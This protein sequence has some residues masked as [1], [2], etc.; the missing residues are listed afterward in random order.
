MDG[1]SCGFLQTRYDNLKRMNIQCHAETPDR[2]IQVCVCA[3][4]SFSKPTRHVRCLILLRL[5]YRMTF[6]KVPRQ[7]SHLT[8]EIGGPA[9]RLYRAVAGRWCLLSSPANCILRLP[10]QSS[11]LRLSTAFSGSCACCSLR[12]FKSRFLPHDQLSHNILYNIRG[13]LICD[14]IIVGLKAT[15]IIGEIERQRQKYRSSALMEW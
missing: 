10:S 5:K 11:T 6:L 9:E 1:A 2:S 3:V 7:L 12:Q 4:Y 15:G 8:R 13:P 14:R